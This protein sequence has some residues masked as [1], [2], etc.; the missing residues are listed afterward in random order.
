M[1]VNEAGSWTV[2]ATQMQPDRDRAAERQPAAAG[3]NA[4]TYNRDP[5]AG[6]AANGLGPLRFIL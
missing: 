3:R 2:L 4:E 5:K 6:E 1:E